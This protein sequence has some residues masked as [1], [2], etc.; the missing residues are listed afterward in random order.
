[1][2]NILLIS[3][4]LL[5][6]GGELGRINPNQYLTIYLHDILVI[7]YLF[8]NLTQLKKIIKNIKKIKNFNKKIF[9]LLFLNIFLATIYALWQKEFAFT[10]L[11]YLA[12]ASAYFL[13]VLF[14]KKEFGQKKI[15]QVFLN[16]SLIMLAIAFLQYLFLPD[17]TSLYHLGFDDHFYRLTGTLLDPNFTGLLFVFNWLYYAKQPKLN[18]KTVFL[19][20]VFLIGIALTYSRAAY[21]SLILASCYLLLKSKKTHKL[22]ILLTVTLF[23]TLIPFLPKKSGGEGVNLQRTSSIEARIVTAKQFINKNQGLTV[24][25]GQ[26][27][28]TPQYQTNKEGLISHARFADNFLIFLYNGFG[29]FGGI[30]ILILLA[31][32]SKKQI[33]SDNH[34]KISLLIALLTHSLFNNNITQAFI[35][36]LF[37]G[38][39]L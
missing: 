11:L 2:K 19:A 35:S 12:R 17:L 6:A 8:F 29:L 15:I 16:A 22:F 33:S 9:L 30:L 28:F 26:G 27:P 10:S 25:V 18:K 3:F 39:Y 4:L 34:F 36:L 5:F 32:E 21:L 20:I 31:Q 24:I 38:L 1:M 13:F 14:L 37:W 23:L 7:A